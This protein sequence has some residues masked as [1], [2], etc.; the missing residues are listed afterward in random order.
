M[1]EGRSHADTSASTQ[2]SANTF[3]NSVHVARLIQ[4]AVQKTQPMIQYLGNK[5]HTDLLSSENKRPLKKADARARGWASSP[6]PRGEPPPNP[7]APSGCPL[8]SSTLLLVA[9]VGQPRYSMQRT[10]QSYTKVPQQARLL[11]SPGHELHASSWGIHWFQY[12]EDLHGQAQKHLFLYLTWCFT[13]LGRHR[14]LL[15][16]LSSNK[17]EL[18]Q[19]LMCA[20]SYAG[21]LCL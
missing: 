9:A 17:T 8:P 20:L 14:M 19:G 5:T 10:E 1:H 15:P 4:H 3:A 11:H 6:L 12:A 16:Q 7:T 13:E 2:S 18:G 21:L